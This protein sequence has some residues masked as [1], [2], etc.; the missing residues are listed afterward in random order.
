LS[1]SRLALTGLIVSLLLLVLCG[2]ATP[3][4]TES[5]QPATSVGPF[6]GRPLGA[7]TLLFD[8]D[9][10]GNF[11]IFTMRLDGGAVRKLTA[12][13]RFDSWWPRVSPDHTRVVFYRTP[14]GVH[15]TDFTQT[16]LWA[17]YVDGTGLRELRPKATDGWDQQGH[18]E[19]SAD[20]KQLLMFG[21]SRSN[22]QIF[23]SD[24]VGRSV[25]QVT[26]RGGTNIDP[27]F[28]PDGATI[29]FVGCPNAICFDKDYEIYTIPT[30]GGE[31]RRLTTNSLRDHDP[32]YSPDGSRIAWLEQTDAT[33]P[34]GAWNVLLMRADGSDQRRVTNDRNINSKP[35]W[36]RD[37]SVIFFHRFEI[38][39]DRW[40]IFSIRP[41]GTAL[42]EITKG[43]PGNNEFPS[44]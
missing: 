29:V 32:Y 18:A 34:T 14:K 15:D 42:T 20:G 1:R 43:A 26:D 17:M 8:S 4:P 6:T 2:R 11:E 38:G 40:R 13:A 37:G 39:G 22:P 35:Q 24:D 31:A 12:D 3:A 44:L 30:R 27:S 19:W 25:R 41:D 7:D 33:G 23:V 16:S 10:D 28:A 9:R 5:T 21:G 36:S